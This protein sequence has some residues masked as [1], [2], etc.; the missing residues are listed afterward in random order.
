MASGTVAALPQACATVK[1][2][3]NRPAFAVGRFDPSP[4]AWSGRNDVGALGKHGIMGTFTPQRF[5]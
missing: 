1:G 5:L 4:Q 3:S 2:S